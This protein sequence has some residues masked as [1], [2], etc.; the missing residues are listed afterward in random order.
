MVWQLGPLDDEELDL[1]QN[2]AERAGISLVDSLAYPGSARKY[3]NGK[4][5]INYLVHYQY[6]ALLPVFIV[7]FILIINSTPKLASAY[8]FY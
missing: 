8:F 6:M 3:I 2:I 7:T 4:R 5:N 1:V